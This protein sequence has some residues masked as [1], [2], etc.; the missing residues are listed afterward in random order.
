MNKPNVFAQFAS[1]DASDDE[2]L[3]E[4]ARLIEMDA[5]EMFHAVSFSWELMGK[6]AIHMAANAMHMSDPM[7]DE[8]QYLIRKLIAV[9]YRCH[10]F[11]RLVLELSDTPKF[12]AKF[13]ITQEDIDRTMAFC[14]ARDKERRRG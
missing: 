2:E 9:A 14:A 6:S 8:S 1:E 13:D 10:V 4:L 5:E 3:G 12:S 7:D 11:S